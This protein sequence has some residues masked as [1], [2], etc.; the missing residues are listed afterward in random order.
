MPWLTSAALPSVGD[1][2]RMP[3]KPKGP[4]VSPAFRDST[5]APF[6][7]FDTAPVFGLVAGTIQIE[8]VSRTLVPTT[9]G[10]AK[11]EFQVTGRLR[12]NPQAARNLRD[13]LNRAL[14]MLEAA[15]SD[16]A[17]AAHGEKLN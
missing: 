7:Y 12:C 11:P 16:N 14:T 3:K 10:G 6:V 8:L 17:H 4:E 13:A 1:I 2:I 5:S 9:D 15:Q